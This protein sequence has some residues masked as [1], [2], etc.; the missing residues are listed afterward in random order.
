MK[1][2]FVLPY[3][4]LQGGIRVIAI[5]ADRLARRGHDVRVVSMPQ[6]F[7]LR[8]KIMSV[9]LGRG[10]PKPE[11]SYFDGSGV[12]HQVLDAPRPVT[13]HDVP[14]GDV[15]IA[16]Y[17][18]TAPGVLALSKTKG[19]KA[20]F[21]QNYEVEPG[22]VNRDLDATWS[23]PLHKIVICK[24]LDEMARTRFGDA[25]ASLVPNS[26]DHAQFTAPPRQKQA[27]P[28][29]GFVYSRFKMKGCKTTLR[30]LEIVARSLPSLRIV[31]FGSERPDF[32]LP[33]PSH[34]EFHYRPR[35]DQLRNHYSQCD[36]WVC[37]SVAEGFGLPLL[38]AMACRCPAVSTR[39]GGPQDF[40]EEGITGH[41]VDV[42]DSI[43]LADRILQVLRLSPERWRKMSNAAYRRATSENWD[44]ATDQFERALQRAVTR[45]G[46]GS[47]AAAASVSSR[48][49]APPLGP[50]GSPLEPKARG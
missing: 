21:I 11:P 48:S 13:E 1:I 26:V 10:I 2:T 5:Y 22:K 32:R 23:M 4:G 49:L 29:V 9:L 38:E 44:Q 28:T 24:W 25:N 50:L 17:Y 3:A 18:T 33:L 27:A 12:A 16:T 42:G 43:A 41:L 7:S 34:A 36:V 37:G 39:C 31:C 47:L 8:H 19:A 6:V 46:N 35:Q 20:I 45:G 15:V 14:D 40:V 30:A